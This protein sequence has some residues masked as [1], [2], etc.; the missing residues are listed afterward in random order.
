MEYFIMEENS[1]EKYSFEKPKA[2]ILNSVSGKRVEGMEIVHCR[3]T[4]FPDGFKSVKWAISDK[5][6]TI[7]EKY[8]PDIFNGI[9]AVINPDTKESCVYKVMKPYLRDGISSATKYRSD[10]TVEK[11]EIDRDKIGPFKIFLLKSEREEFVVVSLEVVERV[12]REE[13]KGI[14][15]KRI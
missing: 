7:L 4:G 14:K 9:V 11:L 3:C 13:I 5:L 12:L 1:G 6:R 8:D 15:F 2:E 10:K